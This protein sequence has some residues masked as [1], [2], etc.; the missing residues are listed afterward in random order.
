MPSRARDYMSFVRTQMYSVMKQAQEEKTFAGLYVTTSV[1][2][3]EPGIITLN[4]H[5]ATFASLDGPPP[6]AKTLRPQ[7]TAAFLAN[8]SGLIRQLDQ[9][10]LRRVPDLSF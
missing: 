6:V 4:M 3:G 8:G 1:Q 10:I 2:G 5:Y 9:S 7:G